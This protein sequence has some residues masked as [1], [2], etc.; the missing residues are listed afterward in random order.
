MTFS[1][2]KITNNFINSSFTNNSFI[3]RLHSNNNTISN[4]SYNN[5]VN[6]IL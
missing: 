1:S 4:S 2:I 5:K 3:P 6:P